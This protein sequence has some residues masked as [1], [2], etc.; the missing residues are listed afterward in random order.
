[1]GTVVEPI[2]M[3]NPF[4]DVV[5]AIGNPADPFYHQRPRRAELL[6]RRPDGSAWKLRC[7]V[8]SMEMTESPMRPDAVGECEP[9]KKSWRDL[10][11]VGMRY[12]PGPPRSKMPGFR[13]AEKWKAKYGSR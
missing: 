1:M 6:L 9:G 13:T 5:Y 12:V 10:V 3:E 11:D 8:E 2:Y 7:M 4:E